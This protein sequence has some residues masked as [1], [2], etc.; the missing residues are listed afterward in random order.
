ML[1]QKDISGR[2]PLRNLAEKAPFELVLKMLTSFG[3]LFGEETPIA[4]LNNK[5]PSQPGL[6]ACLMKYK[7]IAAIKL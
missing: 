7:S 5:D 6:L 4:L 2:S 3:E 1:S